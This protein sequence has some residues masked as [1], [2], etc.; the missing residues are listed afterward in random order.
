MGQNNLKAA[1]DA[2]PANFYVAGNST[3]RGGVRV[4]VTDADL[5]GMDDLVIG[6]GEGV[7]AGVRLYLARDFVGTSEPSTVQ[8]IPVFSGATLTDGVFVG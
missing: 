4:A 3:S 1:Y 7:A 2:P 8:D 5:D 6:S